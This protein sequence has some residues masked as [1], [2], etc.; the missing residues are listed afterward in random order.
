MPL[1]AHERSTAHAKKLVSTCVPTSP[2]KSFDC[3]WTVCAII[4]NL[5]TIP[6][7]TLLDR[8]RVHH[9]R[10]DDRRRDRHP[11]EPTVPR[12]LHGLGGGLGDYRYVRGLDRCDAER[13]VGRLILVKF[14]F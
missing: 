8:S 13:V 12:G 10:D 7:T 6:R 4:L 1:P 5:A 3:C 14:Q 11:A 9:D 2:W